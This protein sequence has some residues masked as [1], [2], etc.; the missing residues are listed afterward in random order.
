MILNEEQR[1]LFTVPHG[2]WLA[3]CISADFALG[4]GIAK[5][6]EERYG[7][8]KMLRLTHG[9]GEPG[10]ETWDFAIWG[11][12][13]LSCSNVLNLVTKEKCFHKPT[14]DTLRTALEDMKLVCFEKGVTKVAMPRIG[15]GLDRLDWD[16]VLPM[17]ED[18]FED[19]DIEILICTL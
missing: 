7:M 19:T 12:A 18:I 2:Y 15:C 8:K 16:D 14:L 17:I 13:C 4:A 6:V 9:D 1:D 5:Q 3:H 10:R 11:P